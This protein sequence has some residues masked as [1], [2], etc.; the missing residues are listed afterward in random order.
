MVFFC[1]SVNEW[2]RCENIHIYSHN[3]LTTKAMFHFS[4]MSE[5]LII[6][7]DSIFSFLTNR[8]FHS[9]VY[10]DNLSPLT[11]KGEIKTFLDCCYYYF[12]ISGIILSDGLS[13]FYNVN[14]YWLLRH[15][16]S[17]IKRSTKEVWEYNI[18]INS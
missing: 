2:L 4:C 1:S 5:Q 7:K 13:C 14:G 12:I 15:L 8:G 9:H 6:F 10:S 18:L 3:F 16:Y 17:A 11:F